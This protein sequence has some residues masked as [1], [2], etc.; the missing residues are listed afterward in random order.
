MISDYD[1]GYRLYELQLRQ[2]IFA[3]GLARAIDFARRHAQHTWTPGNDYGRGAGQAC[4]D[5]YER[6]VGPLSGNP[7]RQQGANA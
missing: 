1:T 2:I 4:V 3:T 6:H 5:F 7:T